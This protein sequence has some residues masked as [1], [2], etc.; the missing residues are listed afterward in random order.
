MTLDNRLTRIL[1]GAA[2]VIVLAACVSVRDRGGRDG[3]APPV[4]SLPASP[5]ASPSGEVDGTTTA[6]EFQR[7]LTGA[8][9]VA[10][11]YWKARF[12]DSGQPFEPISRLVPYRGAGR[13]ACGSEPVPAN[14]A[15]YCPAG[16]FIAYDSAWAL[17]AFRQI[18]DA[19]VY[20]LLGHEYAH[21]I[22]NRLG[23]THRYTVEHEL[24]ADCMAGAYL[25]DTVRVNALRLDSGD[26]GELQAGLL[27][28]ADDPGQP[29][30]APE[31]HG[32]GKQRTDAF[33]EGYDTG[34][35][36]CDLS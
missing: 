25:G 26:L 5:S 3:E 35:K 19:F 11:E 1:A 20:Y 29:W 21:G 14:N 7:D 23:I 15:A 24:Q 16:D 8:M 36:A 28:V 12:E 32:T 17:K 18:G 2:V 13:L 27:A 10:E 6:E 33:F 4:A 9:S 31:S 30:F 22:Q 34:L